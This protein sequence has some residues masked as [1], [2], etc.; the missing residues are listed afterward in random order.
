MILVLCKACCLAVRVIPT[1]VTKATSAREVTDCVGERSDFWPDRFKCPRCD[2]PAR[3]FLEN[4]VDPAVLSLME[5]KD[6]TAMEAFAAFWGMG[7]PEHRQCSFEDLELLLRE[8]PVRRLHGHS[9]SGSEAHVLESIEL[10]DGTRVFLGASPE[11]AV[12]YRV[13]PPF[14]YANR[15]ETADDR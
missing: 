8:K 6:L 1:D 14:S 11:G 7:L 5:V 12:V 10:W 2:A 9:V 3:G 15:L 13:R 4:A